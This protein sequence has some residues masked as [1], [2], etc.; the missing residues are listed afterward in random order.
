METNTARN[1]L[2]DM[3]ER[4]GE[5]KSVLVAPKTAMEEGKVFV[6]FATVEEVEV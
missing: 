5:V 6:E 4:Y 2:D 1:R 3:L